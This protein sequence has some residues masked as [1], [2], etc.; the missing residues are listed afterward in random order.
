MPPKD[1]AGNKIDY[2]KEM[3]KDNYNKTT[4]VLDAEGSSQAFRLLQ[5]YDS[6]GLTLSEINNAKRKMAD[7]NPVNWLTDSASTRVQRV[8]QISDE[9]R[10]WQF[11]QAEKA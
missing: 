11:D 1:S 4:D 7:L 8:K 2:V 3:L 6:E 5:K 9:V 10:T